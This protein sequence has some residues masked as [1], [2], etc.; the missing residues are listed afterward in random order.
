MVPWSLVGPLNWKKA[1]HV[2]NECAFRLVFECCVQALSFE[3]WM[4]ERHPSMSAWIHDSFVF[5][6]MQQFDHTFVPVFFE[7]GSQGSIY[8]HALRDTFGFWR[9]FPVICSQLHQY[10]T[11]YSINLTLVGPKAKIQPLV[12]INKS[13]ESKN[14]H[15]LYKLFAVINID[16]INQKSE[17]VMSILTT[18]E[19]VQRASYKNMFI[20][21]L[22]YSS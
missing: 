14:A 16:F 7:V 4:C 19:N 15:F 11:L 2:G 17:F 13:D 22:Y 21:R 18:I 3:D 12:F 20:A 8:D 10:I 5:F 6:I 9:R 1:A